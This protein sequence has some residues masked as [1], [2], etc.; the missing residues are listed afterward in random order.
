[1]ADPR[2]QGASKSGHDPPFE[3]HYIG[4]VYGMQ[5]I[6]GRALTPLRKILN[7]AQDHFCQHLPLLSCKRSLAAMRPGGFFLHHE[8]VA[9]NAPWAEAAFDRLMVDSLW[10]FHAEAGHDMSR[11]E[12]ARQFVQRKDWSANILAPL[13]QQCQWLREIG[14]VHIDCFFK[15]LEISLFGGRRPE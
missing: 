2:Q 6:M 12:V 9:A 13:D 4:A 3:S 15:A 8:H 14:F 1:M 7:Y 5:R 11:D 10:S